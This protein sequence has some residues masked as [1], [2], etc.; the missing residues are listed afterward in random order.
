MVQ[1]VVK[2]AEVSELQEVHAPT[3]EA[4][5]VKALAVEPQAVKKELP[6]PG[7]QCLPGRKGRAPDA[8]NKMDD[9]QH[10][11]DEASRRKVEVRVKVKP[12]RAIKEM[13]D[14][15][16]M[17]EAEAQDVQPRTKEEVHAGAKEDLVPL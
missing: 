10:L 13:D 8:A 14:V 15:G 11:D 17:V 5:E 7:S 6:K 4:L 16:N 2:A 9:L 1:D 3:V 12:A